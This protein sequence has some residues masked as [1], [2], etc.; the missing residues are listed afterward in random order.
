MRWKSN[1]FSRTSVSF[2]ITAAKPSPASDGKINYWEKFAYSTLALQTFRAT[3]LPAHSIFHVSFT[4][5]E[6]AATF[7]HPLAAYCFSLPTNSGVVN[8]THVKKDDGRRRR[9]R[10]PGAG[11]GGRTNFELGVRKWS[12]RKRASERVNTQR[13]CANRKRRRWAER[14]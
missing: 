5:R 10:W 9:W 1:S 7:P 8:P 14:E 6:N 12:K 2:F 4:F 3:P 13:R 11:A